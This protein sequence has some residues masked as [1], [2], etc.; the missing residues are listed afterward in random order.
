[1]AERR[2]RKKA[3][4]RV[5]GPFTVQTFTTIGLAHGSIYRN[6]EFFIQVA[7]AEGAQELVDILNRAAALS[8]R[9][10]LLSNNGDPDYPRSQV[11]YAVAKAM[12]GCIDFD[13]FR[14]RGIRA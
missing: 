7:T 5:A 12:G 10:D 2:P 13:T 3:P 11:A 9:A 8:E 14:E 4:T 1:M 6:G